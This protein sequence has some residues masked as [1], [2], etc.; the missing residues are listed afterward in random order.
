M[1]T[2]DKII[3]LFCHQTTKKSNL[4]IDKKLWNYALRFSLDLNWDWLVKLDLNN[5][6]LSKLFN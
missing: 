1:H 6:Q 3:L 5:N 2:E 4:P